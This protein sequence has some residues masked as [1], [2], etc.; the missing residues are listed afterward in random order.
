MD[1]PTHGTAS[2]TATLPIRHPSTTTTT[3]PS[4]SPRY[5]TIDG[6]LGLLSEEESLP[7]LD[8]S[9]V[10]ET[11]AE[12]RVVFSE[13]YQGL[14]NISRIPLFSSEDVVRSA[15]GFSLFTVLLSTWALTFA[16]GGEKLFGPMWDKLVMYNVAEELGLTGPVVISDLGT[17]LQLCAA[18]RHKAAVYIAPAKLGLRSQRSS[19]S[20]LS[21]SVSSLLGLEGYMLARPT[22]HLHPCP[23]K[24]S[25]TQIARNG[26][27]RE[28]QSHITRRNPNWFLPRLESR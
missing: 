23:G 21:S 11:Q 22:H 4:P 9:L 8:Y 13:I 7:R 17:C 1:R 20:Q 15:V 14:S 12:F 24:N 28:K 6:P 16:I 26:G 25:E 10:L 18:K 2:P 27:K 19:S 5:P 3:T